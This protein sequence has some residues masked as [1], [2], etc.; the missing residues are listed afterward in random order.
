MM[1]G[2]SGAEHD[3]LPVPA[4]VAAIAS[5]ARKR[6]LAQLRLSSTPI[7]TNLLHGT[8]GV[9]WLSEVMPLRLRG[10]G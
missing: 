6:A 5:L 9:L 7:Q 8:D 1:L 2:G 4:Y 3:Q 10:S